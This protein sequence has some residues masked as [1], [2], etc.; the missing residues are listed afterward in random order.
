MQDISFR[1]FGNLQ[2][3]FSSWSAQDKTVLAITGRVITKFTST[4]IAF[5]AYDSGKRLGGYYIGKLRSPCVIEFYSAQESSREFK[6]TGEQL[7]FK[8][9]CTA[10]VPLHNVCF[11]DDTRMI[12]TETID[13]EIAAFLEAPSY[14]GL[15]DG[16]WS[17]SETGKTYQHRKRHTV[18]D[19]CS[20]GVCAESPASQRR[21]VVEDCGPEPSSTVVALSTPH[22]ASWTEVDAGV[23][24]S[25]T[26]F[27][28]W[29]NERRAFAGTEIVA[30]P[31]RGHDSKTTRRYSIGKCVG[32]G[33]AQGNY[34][35][36]VYA[37]MG[38]GA[39]VPAAKVDIAVVDVAL[40]TPLHTAVEYTD[41]RVALAERL[42]DCI[43]QHASLGLNGG[44]LESRPAYA[45][46]EKVDAEKELQNV[47]IGKWAQRFVP[48]AETAL[49]LDA[50]LYRT[51]NKLL[52]RCARIKHIVVP[53]NSFGD[54]MDMQVVP[55]C[56]ALLPMTMLRA[57]ETWDV[58][59]SGTLDV[60][61]ADTC[62]NFNE[63][64]KNSIRVAFSK[65]SDTA[66]LTVTVSTRNNSRKEVRAHPIE[67]MSEIMEECLRT[68]S[69]RIV[70]RKKKN[71]ET[72]VVKEVYAYGRGMF[73]FAFVVTKVP[74]V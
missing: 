47:R 20:D 5:P 66:L 61:V 43:W 19:E 40:F 53:N 21:R 74:V 29:S 67:A 7:R 36:M 25:N 28:K 65:F 18:V 62:S 14:K 49:V 41:G 38:D 44:G 24:D 56:T 31:L 60:L 52:K 3:S 35:F 50:V 8:R 64:L 71:G 55:K 73:F 33:A 17:P 6:L 42:E 68:F 23:R 1:L 51:S 54:V 16:H 39:Y 48:C 45:Y 11:I 27:T 30:I 57:L 70:D 10:I 34:S 69:F 12:M 4:V 9:T 72:K 15:E 26:R 63:D 2:P 13:S 59:A 32:V 58:R 37:V 46:G 22:W